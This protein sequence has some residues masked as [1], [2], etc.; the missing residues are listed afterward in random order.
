MA[1]QA[2]LDMLINEGIEHMTP[3]EAKEQRMRMY[4]SKQRRQ[5]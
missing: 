4:R 2:D 1:A 3:E 5:P